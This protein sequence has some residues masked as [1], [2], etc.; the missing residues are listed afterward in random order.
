ML[1]VANPVISNSPEQWRVLASETQVVF[2]VPSCQVDH[3]KGWCRRRWCAFCSSVSPGRA[4]AKD[5]TL[6]GL[7]HTDEMYLSANLNVCTCMAR[8][9]TLDQSTCYMEIYVWK[10]FFSESRFT[11]FWFRFS[12]SMSLFIKNK[13]TDTCHIV[14]LVISVYK[15]KKILGLTA[16]CRK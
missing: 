11:L 10:S 9:T 4:D 7:I 13:W 3:E 1:Q 5:S 16:W 12:S 2:M 15:K 8:I 6:I 14:S